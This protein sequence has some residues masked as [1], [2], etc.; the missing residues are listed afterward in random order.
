[1]SPGGGDAGS[2]HLLAIKKFRHGRWQNCRVSDRPP[3][4]LW[5]KYGLDV[6]MLAVLKPEAFDWG[7][8]K[9][10]DAHALKY[11]IS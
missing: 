3:Q 10:P 2:N 7:S 4:F 11:V 9:L 6:K 5:L 8:D 1:M